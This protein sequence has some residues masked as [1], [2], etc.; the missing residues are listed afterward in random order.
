MPSKSTHGPVNGS[1]SLLLMAE[2]FSIVHMHHSFF[3]HLS[4]NGLLGFHTLAIVNST[5]MNTGVH[6]SFLAS[7]FFN[8]GEF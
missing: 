8:T 5:A 1:V 3:I 4:V 7:F 6:V 2:Y